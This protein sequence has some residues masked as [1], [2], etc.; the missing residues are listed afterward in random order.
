VGG[1]P[2]ERGDG[3]LGVPGDDDVGGVPHQ[4][5]VAVLLDGRLPDLRAEQADEV[6]GQVLERAQGPTAAVVRRNWPADRLLE[7]PQRGFQLVVGD[8]GEVPVAHGRPH[9]RPRARIVEPREVDLAADD[10]VLEVVDGVG[11]VVREVHH[12]CL[13][14][15]TTPV[16]TV[17][18]PAEDL[19][20]VVVDAELA[21]RPR[22]AVRVRAVRLLGRLT[23]PGVLRARVERGPREVEAHGAAVGVE[24]LGVQP[25]QDAQRLGVALEASAGVAHLVER[26][27][28]VVPE[29]R[30]AE[31]VRERG[32]LDDV[33]VAAQG[34]AEVA[35]DLRD[36]EGVGQ[37]VAHEVVGLRPDDLR[38]GREPAQRRR[39]HEPGPVALERRA[40]VRRRALG[41]LDHPAGAGVL[42]VL[43]CRPH[44]ERPYCRAPTGSWAVGAVS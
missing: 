6:A 33:R 8:T 12:L 19:Q 31:V 35:C 43:R 4:R 26:P 1:H 10:T 44:R 3:G 14:A 41:R 16:H 25:G 20:V 38:L 21:H 29:R 36:L 7:Q 30:V 37:P 5:Q 28:T 27:L 9:V 24:G 42:V 13:D 34:P 17:A 2:L 40:I 11:H 22:G 15:P 18:E 32:G 23:W 39:V